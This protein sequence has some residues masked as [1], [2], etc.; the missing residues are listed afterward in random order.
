[1]TSLYAT[2]AIPRFRCN[3]INTFTLSCSF[4]RRVC[5]VLQDTTVAMYITVCYHQ[6]ARRGAA[7]SAGGAAGRAGCCTTHITMHFLFSSINQ[8]GADCTAGGGAG[9]VVCYVYHVNLH[10][11]YRIQV[12]AGSARET[13]KAGGVLLCSSVLHAYVKSCIGGGGV[14]YYRVL[15]SITIDQRGVPEGYSNYCKD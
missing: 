4:L 10:Q 2:R 5:A 8:R 14:L 13:Q 9:T 15:S 6:P 1:V 12:S 11:Q 7:D 3:T